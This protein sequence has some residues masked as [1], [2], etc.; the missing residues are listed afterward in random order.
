[1]D[2]DPTPDQ[3]T[4]DQPTTEP[5]AAEPPAAAPRVAWRERVFRFRAVLAVALA[6]IVLGTGV[7]VLGTLVFDH[8]QDR[9]N[10]MERF[11]RNGPG[12]RPDFPGQ[13]GP[14]GQNMPPLGTDELPP[15]TTP[16][17]D[18]TEP[19]PQD[20]NTSSS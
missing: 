17:Q 9:S 6:S 7:G 12:E 19:T 18:E 2:H 16:R 1:M 13:G 10:R 4:T 20:D 15:G 3:P 5:P 11:E 14:G 8:D